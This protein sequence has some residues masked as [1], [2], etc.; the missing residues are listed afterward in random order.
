MKEESKESQ[1]RNE[2]SHRRIPSPSRCE[3]DSKSS[4]EILIQLKLENYEWY[5]TEE[6]YE[7]K[8]Q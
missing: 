1:K 7:T 3:W 8:P 2:T 5:P 4:L 6:F